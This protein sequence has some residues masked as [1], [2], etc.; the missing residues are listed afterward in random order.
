M[1]HRWQDYRDF[2]NEAYGDMS[3]YWNTPSLLE[4]QSDDEDDYLDESESEYEDN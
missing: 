1:V 4:S 2:Q 3:P